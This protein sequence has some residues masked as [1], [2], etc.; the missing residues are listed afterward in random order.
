MRNMLKGLRFGSTKLIMSAGFLLLAAAARQPETLRRQIEQIST[1]AQGRVGVAALLL[2]AGETV[3]LNG[4]ERFPMQSVYKFPIG[5][6]VLH[7]V[8][9]G[10]LRL[11]Q[12]VRVEKRVLVPVRVHSPL[13]RHA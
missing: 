11:D 3:T 7:E 6:A 4:D 5:M 13:R 1:A 12:T 8:D 10:A 9:R 2:P